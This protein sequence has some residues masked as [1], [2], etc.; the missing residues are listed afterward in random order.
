M[1]IKIKVIVKILTWRQNVT[2]K[3]KIIQPKQRKS[4]YVLKKIKENEIESNEIT[5]MTQSLSKLNNKFIEKE[6]HLLQ[7]KKPRNW[8]KMGYKQI[9][10]RRII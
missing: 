9:L 7:Q 5:V 3:Q 1:K 10:H 6:V 8:I 4:S 2:M